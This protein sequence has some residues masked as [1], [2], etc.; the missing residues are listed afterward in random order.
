[1]ITPDVLIAS[2]CTTLASWPSTRDMGVR[3]LSDLIFAFG[4]H[5]RL[6]DLVMLYAHFVMILVA[7]DWLADR[8]GSA[9]ERF[10]S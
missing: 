9:L 8:I 7:L 1:M 4:P 3:I 2:L 6:L 5:Q 10:T